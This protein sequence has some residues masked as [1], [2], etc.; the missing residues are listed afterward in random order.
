M[1]SVMK[2][3]KNTVTLRRAAAVAAVVL[4][5]GAGSAFAGTTTVNF[6][7]NPNTTRRKLGSF[8]G[9]AS[10]DDATGLL[11]VTVNNTSTS[12]KKAASLTGVAFNIAGTTAT[13]RYVDGDDAATPRADEDAFDDARKRKGVIKAKPLGTYDA[14]TA[15]NGK[16]GAASRRAA[17]AGVLAG[18]SRTFVFDV[19]NAGAG[20]SAGDFFSGNVGIAASFRGKKPDRVGGVI[21]PATP[22]VPVIPGPDPIDNTPPVIDLPDDNTGGGITPPGDIGGGGD[23]GTGGNTGGNNGGNTGGSNGGPA[24]VPL[25]PAVWTGFAGLA[26]LMSPKLKKKLRRLL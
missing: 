16:F 6:E 5:V 8:T 7:S 23:N 10:Y 9:T 17:A 12:A 19:D 3:S 2:S 18:S 1:M 24:A 22:S 21:L 25:P 11:S 15:V 13:A 20:M 26:A 14:G 4:G